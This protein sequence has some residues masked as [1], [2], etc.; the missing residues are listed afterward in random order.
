MQ[1]SSIILASKL[2][3]LPG[4]RHKIIT[5]ISLVT[6]ILILRQEDHA[7]SKSSDYLQRCSHWV[8]VLLTCTDSCGVVVLFL[9]SYGFVSF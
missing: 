8:C 3:Y 6:V 1:I 5:K 9:N 7:E 2:I 4:I